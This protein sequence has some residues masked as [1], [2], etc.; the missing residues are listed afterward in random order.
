MPKINYQ[1]KNCKN[2]FYDYKSRNQI[3]CSRKCASSGEN[4]A[5][6]LGGRI[7]KRNC[8]H[9]KKEFKEFISDKRMFCC[10][11]CYS[12]DMRGFK[13][14]KHPNYK[15]KEI[16]YRG[17]HNR[18]DNFRGKP[19]LCEVCGLKNKNKVYHW[20]NLTGKLYDI[21]DY[22]RMCV[23]CH[24]KYDVKRRIKNGTRLITREKTIPQTPT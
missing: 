14:E 17:F 12:K 24:R 15:R 1:C 5:G 3:F 9:C 20:A 23:S 7:E 22:K 19:K 4:N 10:K 2:S 21:K 13:G 6:W 8:L 16:S 11:K 18:V